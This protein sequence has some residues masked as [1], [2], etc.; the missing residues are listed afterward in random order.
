MTGAKLVSVPFASQ[1][2]L[3]T[4]MSPKTDKE[5]EQMSNVPYSSAIGSIKYAMVC[6][7]PEISHVVSVVSRYMACP[8]KEHWQAV[9]WI[10]RYL[11]GTANVGLTF[12]KVKLS[13]SVVGYVDSDYAGDLDKRRSLTGYVFTLSGSVISWKATLQSVVSLSTT[14]AEYMAITEAVKEAIWLQGLVSDLGL[15]QKKT[16]VF[17]DSQSAIHLTKNQMFHERTKHID[18]KHHFIRDIVSKGLVDVK[19]VSTHDNPADMITKAV[20][21]NKFRHCLDL[22]GVCNTQ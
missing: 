9:K 10:L 12:S 19:K 15:D 6:T 5:M 3:S 7:R 14:E 8:G 1:F 11:K 18:V 16:L 17:Y 22:I 13:E 4:D 21:T 20:P 2:K